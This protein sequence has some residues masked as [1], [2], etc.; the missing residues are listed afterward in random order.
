MRLYKNSAKG[1]TVYVDGS[2]NAQVLSLTDDSEPIQEQLGLSPLEATIVTNT[3][4]PSP[5]NVFLINQYRGIKQRTTSV[6]LISAT[7]VLFLQ[8]R[9]HRW[10]RRMQYPAIIAV[11]NCNVGYNILELTKKSKEFKFL[12]LFNSYSLILAYEEI[13]THLWLMIVQLITLLSGQHQSLNHQLVA[14]H[15]LRLQ[16]SLNPFH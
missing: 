8:W 11:L 4:T 12:T 1:G 16:Q 9:Q 14:S 15:I 7:C 2:R 13:I 6:E 10:S 3:N 5:N